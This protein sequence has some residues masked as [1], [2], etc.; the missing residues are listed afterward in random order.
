[1]YIRIKIRIITYNYLYSI[2]NQDNTVIHQHTKCV[3]TYWFRD[4]ET[5]IYAHYIVDACLDS[6]SF[7]EQQIPLVLLLQSSYLSVTFVFINSR[8]TFRT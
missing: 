7:F 8:T 3:F 6:I 2:V 1:M 5:G 4:R